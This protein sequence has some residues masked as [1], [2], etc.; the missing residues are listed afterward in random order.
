MP[1]LTARQRAKAYDAMVQA[2]YDEIVRIF[3]KERADT[4]NLGWGDSGDSYCSKVYII[5]NRPDLG[6]EIGFV[7]TLYDPVTFEV[8]GHE[9]EGEGDE[10]P[11]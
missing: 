2:H 1:K 7:T 9:C 6:E 3:G 10:D 8:L 11:E 5:P 4:A